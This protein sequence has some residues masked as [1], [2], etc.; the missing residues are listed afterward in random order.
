VYII[1]SSLT[2]LT[3]ELERIIF[4]TVSENEPRC[5]WY[6]SVKRE[7]KHTRE[8]MND[9][10]VIGNLSV[11]VLY[12]LNEG[13]FVCPLEYLDNMLAT[14]LTIVLGNGRRD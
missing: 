6:G 5:S 7:W 11:G 3:T 2:D 1:P 10:E 12:L 9:G 4:I 8:A 13:G 14:G